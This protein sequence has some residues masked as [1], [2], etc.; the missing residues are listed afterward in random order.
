MNNALFLDFNTLL[1]SNNPLILFFHELWDTRREESNVHFDLFRFIPSHS[2][3]MAVK[4]SW[5]ILHLFN[6]LIFFC[7]PFYL[8]SFFFCRSSVF[9]STYQENGDST[10]LRWF[11][12]KMTIPPPGH[13]LQ[14]GRA[15]PL[16]V[17]EG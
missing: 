8:L 12:S 7:S 17:L 4:T 13:P 14:Y 5:H 9:L 11:I 2:G 1:P 10:I 16:I 6:P 3:L 15:E